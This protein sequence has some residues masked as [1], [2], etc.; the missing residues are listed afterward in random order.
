MHRM[1][2]VAKPDGVPLPPPQPPVDANRTGRRRRR[3]LP[4]TPSETP[5]RGKTPSSGKKRKTPSRTPVLF[6]PEELRDVTLKPTPARKKTPSSTGPR[7]LKSSIT[8][9][10]S[11][12]QSARLKKVGPPRTRTTRQTNPWMATLSHEI[13]KRRRELDPDRPSSQELKGLEQQW[14]TWE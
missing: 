10:S 11:V 2:R 12:S 8:P 14:K 1:V 4:P 6:T 5:K 13:D 7:H 3:I 9:E